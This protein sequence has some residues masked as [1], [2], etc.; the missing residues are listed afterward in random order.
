MQGE[1]PFWL[2]CSTVLEG[3]SLTLTEVEVAMTYLAFTVSPLVCSNH[4]A[5]RVCYVL[6]RLSGTPFILNGLNLLTDLF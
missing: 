1:V 3:I 5:N 4:L 2:T 6:P